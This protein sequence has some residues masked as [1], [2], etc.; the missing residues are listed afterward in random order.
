MWDEPPELRRSSY[1]V[2][3][4]KVAERKQKI[5]RKPQLYNR[6]E[7]MSRAAFIILYH[8]KSFIASSVSHLPSFFASQRL[9][10]SQKK[11]R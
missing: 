2:S 9:K 5:R 11:N 6:A 3:C 4:S 7:T 10:V 8:H 1:L